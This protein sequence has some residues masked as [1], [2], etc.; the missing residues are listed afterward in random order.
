MHI[1]CTDRI[2]V[3]I[4]RL[5]GG[6]SPILFLPKNSLIPIPKQIQLNS[7]VLSLCEPFAAAI[8]AV[9]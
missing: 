7:I 8:Q 5:H 3:G 1:H 4:D 6:T 2:T 9:W